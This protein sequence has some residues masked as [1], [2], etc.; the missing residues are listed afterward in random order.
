M[1]SFSGYYI[2]G[3]VCC[4][5]RYSTR[6]YRSIN[7]MSSALWTDG[8]REQ[9][10]MPNDHGLRRCKCGNYFLQS[11]LIAISEVDETDEPLAP[12]VPPEDLPAAISQARTQAIELASRLDYWQHLNHAYRDLYRAHRD[13]EDAATQAAWEA[14]NPDQ[15]TAWQKLRKI[16]RK[17]RYDPEIVRPITFP[18]FEA[19]PAQ[20]ENM[21]ALLKLIAASDKPEW[22]A[23][24]R[25]ELHRELGQFDE[26]RQ[27]LQRVDQ[28]DSASECRLVLWLIDQCHAAPVR[29]GA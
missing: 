15:R 12:R 14:A 1:T 16:E 11:E 18:V 22:H 2:N 29:Y 26:A 28:E 9:S 20:R 3:A 23:F 21:L 6:R 13:A 17:P 5:A 24:S 10:L 27:A 19:S 25:V 8:Y 7:F 4:G